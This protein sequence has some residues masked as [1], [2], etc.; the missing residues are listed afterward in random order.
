MNAGGVETGGGRR[1]LPTHE[2]MDVANGEWRDF[3]SVE[4]LHS[5]ATAQSVRCLYQS[6]NSDDL[7]DLSESIWGCCP[8]V[9]VRGAP[10][11]DPISFPYPF[12]FPQ[13]APRKTLQGVRA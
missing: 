13:G 8:R 9:R 1:E 7:P 4:V 2:G 10:S 12:L 3:L 6:E 11:R 5:Q